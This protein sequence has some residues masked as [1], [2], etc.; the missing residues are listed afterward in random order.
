MKGRKLPLETR[1]KQSQSHKGVPNVK[2][3]K[4]VKITNL[5][6]NEVKEFSCAFCDECAEYLGLK[7]KYV[8]CGCVGNA[9]KHHNGI[10]RKGPARK[11]YDAFKAEYLME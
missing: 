10:I 4:T 2:K 9:I 7:N 8:S 3:R 11:T 6:T 1:L 5:L